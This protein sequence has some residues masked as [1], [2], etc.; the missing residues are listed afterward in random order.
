MGAVVVQSSL[1]MAI[2]E[3]AYSHPTCISISFN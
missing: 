1:R 2:S 3:R